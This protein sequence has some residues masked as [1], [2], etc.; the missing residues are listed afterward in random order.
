MGR[1]EVPLNPHLSAAHRF[2][3]ELRTL[4]KARRLSLAKLGPQLL[5]SDDL[6]RLIELAERRPSWDFA[7]RCDE[8]LGTT[9]G[10]FLRLW[11]AI[12]QE[13]AA[14]DKRAV[15]TDKRDVGKKG[16]RDHGQPGIADDTIAVEMLSL[17]GESIHVPLTRRSLVAGIAG[18]PAVSLI[19]GA[20]AQ[21]PDGTAADLVANSLQLR[22]LLAVQDNLLG[23]GAVLPAAVHQVSILR[24]I[25]RTATGTTRDTLKRAQAAYGEFCGWLTDDLGDHRAGQQWIDQALEWA[26]EGDDD[27]VVSYILMRK[28]QRAGDQGDAAGAIGLA[29]A[30]LRTGEVPQR[31]I[32]AA[33]QYEAQGHALDGNAKA[34]EGA[35]EQAHQVLADQDRRDDSSWAPWCTPAYID[36]HKAAGWMRLHQPAA[37]IASYEMALRGWA[38]EYQRDLGLYYARLGRA[39]ADAQQP[40]PAAARGT[41]ALGIARGTGSGRILAELS[42]LGKTLQPWRRLPAVAAF[43]DGL[44][45]ASQHHTTAN[46]NLGEGEVN[47]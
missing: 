20:P 29:R 16:D 9:D 10:V 46:L 47:R 33:R 42:P 41:D 15:V 43:L 17:T 25:S 34:F 35:I 37:A 13:A 14:T 1:P 4:R 30:A 27:V 31:M 45:S 2:G 26:Y 23:P 36:V 11:T 39:Y 8:A 12:E 6:V 18:I 22:E 28:A 24:R 3:F 38:G 32:A 7:K 44:R 19:P 40:E 21:I 5:A